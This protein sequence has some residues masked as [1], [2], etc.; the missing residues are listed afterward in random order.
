L[1]LLDLT[2][3]IQEITEKTWTEGKGESARPMREVKLKLTTAKHA[4]LESL[5]KHLTRDEDDDTDMTPEQKRNRIAYLIA[6]KLEG[7][8]ADELDFIAINR[9]DPKNSQ[10]LAAFTAARKNRNQ[11]DGTVNPWPI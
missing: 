4:A 9:R 10:E 3:A 6:K 1:P 8:S 5:R 11:E 7:K 2:A